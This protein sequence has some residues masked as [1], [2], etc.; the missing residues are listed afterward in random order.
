M[1]LSFGAVE[2]LPETEQKQLNN[3][4][5]IYSYHRLKNA[6]K[7]R[8]YNGHIS[9][10]EVN[11]GIA[12]PRNM[13]KLDV[14]CSWGAKA[15]DVLAS[16][17]M[18]DGFVAENGAEA[19]T[20]TEIAKRNR[21]IAEYQKACRDELLYGATFACVSG[22][23]GGSVIRFYSPQC[24]AG[25]WSNEK[26][27]IACGFAFQDAM[28][29]ESD[30]NWTPTFVNLY[31]ETDTW[32]L[33]REGGHWTAERSPHKF[34]RPLMEPMIWNASSDKPFGQN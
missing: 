22:E 27:R 8:Y 15:V 25:A 5:R 6:C 29:D 1:T 28:Q 31:T 16:R 24:A 10:A 21:L 17:S 34:G 12:L 3:L 18:F 4:V 2:G 26:G 9:L 13:S 7:Q 14:G 30:I 33:S 19:D 32:E 23:K 20:M 11:L